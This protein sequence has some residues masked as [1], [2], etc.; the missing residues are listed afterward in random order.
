[1]YC[2]YKHTGPTG[3][4]YIGITKR[5][6]YKRW[7]HGRGYIDNRYFYRA[8]EKYGWDNFT[9]EI[10][11]TKLSQSEAVERE[12]YYIEKYNSTDPEF[13]YNIEAGGL[14]GPE[15]FTESMRKT[16]SER[17]KRVT[18]ERPELLKI[19]QDAQ[20]KYFADE[21]NRQRQS[22]RLKQHYQEHP[23]A[24]EQ[25]SRKCKERWTDEYRKRFGK[26]QKAVQGMPE[27]RKRA[28]DTHK[29]QM[30]PIEQIALDGCVVAQ[31]ECIGDAVRATGACRQ[32]IS[33]VLKHKKT[34]AGNE[35]QT[36]GGY[37]WR[38]L[39]ER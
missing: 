29:S 26:T 31:Y 24:R 15:R 5:N 28:R 9:H 38:Y 14:F 3:K 39:D 1:M 27:A 16:F 11:E 30:R 36:A 18:T 19:M 6:P 20:R 23:E 2:V 35:R 17:G 7:N 4:V 21:N 12:R 22:E 37:K 34:K 10:I 13:G 8:I 25:I 32:N 33:C